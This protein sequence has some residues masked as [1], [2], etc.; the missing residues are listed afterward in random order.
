MLHAIKAAAS[1][2]PVIDI[3]YHRKA[4]PFVPQ[5]NAKCGPPFRELTQLPP[6]VIV[7]VRPQTRS[8]VEARYGLE[9][10]ILAVSS[11]KLSEFPPPHSFHKE[12][13]SKG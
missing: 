9:F 7:R 1:D 6:I 3:A 8:C 4:L 11:S 13:P 10:H 12:G 2:A 5:M